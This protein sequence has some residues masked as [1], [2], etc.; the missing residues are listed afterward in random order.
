MLN[1]IFPHHWADPIE[2]EARYA[3]RMFNGLLMGKLLGSAIIGVS[4]FAGTA[5]MEFGS[6]APISAIA[7]VPLFAVIYDIVRRLTSF[8]LHK[9][10]CGGPIEGYNRA[11]HPSSAEKE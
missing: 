2:E 4:W 1:G 7:G 5:L 9:Y 6:A 3:G 8:G 10:N 11:F